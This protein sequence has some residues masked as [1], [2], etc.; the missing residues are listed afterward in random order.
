MIQ[1]MGSS[2]IAIIKRSGG[3]EQEYRV[4][5]EGQIRYHFFKQQLP[6]ICLNFEIA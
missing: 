1:L 3:G 5:T 4:N 6:I 2:P